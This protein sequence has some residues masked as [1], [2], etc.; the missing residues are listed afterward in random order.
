MTCLAHIRRKFTDI[1]QAEALP[2]FDDL[3]AWPHAQLPRISGKSERA[4]AI[5]DPPPA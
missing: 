4:K 2:V 1:F 5:R 3:E